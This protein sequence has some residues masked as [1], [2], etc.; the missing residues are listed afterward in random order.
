MSV[1][2]GSARSDENGKA[3]G[4]PGDQKSG[5]EVSTQS[6][7]LHKKGWVIIRI[8]D[9]QKAEKN[10]WAMEKACENPHFG[11]GQADRN[12]GYNAAKAVGFDP[13][14]VTK[15]VNIDCSK[16]VQLCLAYAGITVPD[17]YT[18]NMKS[19]CKGMPKTFEVIE[20][21]KAQTSDYLLRGDILVTK[22]KGHTVIVLSNGAKAKAS[23]VSKTEKTTRKT[24]A[25]VAAEVLKGKWGNGEERRKKLQAAGYDCAA[26]QAA[27][28]SLI[29]RDKT[30]EA[31]A[32][33]VIA[34]KWG[35]GEERKEKLKAAGYDAEAVQKKVNELTEAKL[36][37][38]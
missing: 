16:L 4:K 28:N 38:R 12:T 24:V 2:I 23:A 14:K 35:N 5:N 37:K 3:N 31:V 21:A 19:I 34:G 10:A 29:I 32:K 25:E 36:D 15:N 22:T 33:E 27:V 11:Y 26:V 8:R 18:G 9:S 13:S 17:W 7:Y 30:A 6:W 1:K 20:G